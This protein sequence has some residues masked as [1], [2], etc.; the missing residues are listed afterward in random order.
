MTKQDIAVIVDPRTGARDIGVG[1]DGDLA[2]VSGAETSI[3]LS[4]MTNR[5]ADASEVLQPAERRGWIGDLVARVEGFK[6]GSKLWLYEQRRLDQNT[7]NGVRDAA[8]K[9]LAWFAERGFADRV[10]AEAQQNGAG[11]IRLVARIFVGADVVARSFTIWNR[12]KL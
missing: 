4:I 7:V 5:R 12:T 6:V 3:D 1:A 8:Q 11:G 2:A 10:E 9:G